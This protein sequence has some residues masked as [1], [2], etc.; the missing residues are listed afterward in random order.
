MEKKEAGMALGI[1]MSFRYGLEAENV[2]I[3][4][5]CLVNC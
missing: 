4:P 5:E 3:I 1:S 2:K